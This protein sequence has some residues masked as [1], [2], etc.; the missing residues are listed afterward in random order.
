MGVRRMANEWARKVGQMLRNVRP[1]LGSLAT[2]RLDLPRGKMSITSPAFEDGGTIPD[3]YTQ[4]G[5][6]L[7]PPLEWHNLPEG[8][9]SL[10]LIIEDADAPFPRPLVH[11]VLHSIP[12]GLSGI[13]EGGLGMKQIRASP[14]GFQVGRNSMARPG[15]M[16]PS[17]IPGHGPHRYAFQLF[18]A[19]IVPSFA[20]PPGRGQVLR[21]LKGNLLAAARLIGVYQRL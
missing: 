20:S 15:W 7:F 8:T 18:A 1:G 10:A 19:D 17:P 16:A 11:A 2:S 6:A 3:R 21:A 5:E 4:D 12:P 9:T 14:L 13:Q